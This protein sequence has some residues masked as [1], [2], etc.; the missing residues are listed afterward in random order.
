[1]M[2]RLLA[3]A[4]S[5][6]LAGGMFLAGMAPAAAAPAHRSGCHRYHSCPSDTG[7]YTCGD[8]GDYSQCPGGDPTAAPA[9]A[10]APQPMPATPPPA[11]RKPGP[12]HYQN[13]TALR[14]DYPGGVQLPGATNK[15]GHLRRHAT[16]NAEVYKA[17]QR[18]DR[19]HDGLACEN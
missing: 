5:A 16:V 10:P 8:L 9:P 18:L 17:N 15:G 6:P 7:S 1:M 2:R 14:H 3:L 11:P 4:L 19:D 12:K 13:C